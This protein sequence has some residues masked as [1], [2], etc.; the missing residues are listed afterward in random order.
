MQV[1]FPRT[2]YRMHAQVLLNQ[3]LCLQSFPALPSLSSDDDDDV[4]DDT[5]R[6]DDD[7]GPCHRHLLV[8]HLSP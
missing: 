6:D 3:P 8:E 7:G 5:A 2:K 1:R 4:D